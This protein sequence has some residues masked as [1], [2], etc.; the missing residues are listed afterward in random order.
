MVPVAVSWSGGKDSC[1]AMIRAIKLGFV[2]KVLLNMMNENGKISRRILAEKVFNDPEKLK[3]L[4]ALIHPAVLK[5]IEKLYGRASKE[6]LYSSFVVEIPLLFEIEGDKF[7]DVVVAVL[8]D[9]A[10]AKK[11]FEQ[12]GFQKSEYE[13][14][15][16]RQL[17]PHQKS[18]RAHYT[19]HNNG[20]LEDLRREVIKLNQI[21]QNKT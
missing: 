20:S 9:E 8:S 12:A 19:I 4:E 14:R 11:R 5:K 18:T 16:S 13:R 6:D 21:I 7:Y 1:F 3:L 10:V 17:K 2:P 15:M